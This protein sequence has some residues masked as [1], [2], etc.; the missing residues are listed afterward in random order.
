VRGLISQAH[1]I[2][3]N[4]FQISVEVRDI[5]E[6][7]RF[8]QKVLGCSE[9]P[10]DEQWI[11]SN[12]YGHQIVCRLNTGL[13]R[14]G[15]VASRYHLVDGK[16]VPIAH[17]IVTL[18]MSEWRSLATRLTQ[19]RVK[20]ITEPHQQ[21]KSATG[22]QAM[23]C[24]LDPSGNALAVQSLCNSAEEILR[25]KRQR[26]LTVWLRWAILTAFIACV[27]L[28]LLKNSEDGIAQRDFTTAA[29]IPACPTNGSCIR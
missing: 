21:S 28:L 6:A 15:R 12:L 24:F 2:L 1:H 25:Y 18:E 7:R 23:L 22:V 14:L 26:A 11:E 9:G 19:H 13:G 16:Y 8:Y 17:S 10:C 27:I 20:F 29:Y 4:S 5:A 3:G